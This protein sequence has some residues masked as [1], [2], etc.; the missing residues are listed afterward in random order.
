MLHNLKYAA[1]LYVNGKCPFQLELLGY[2]CFWGPKVENLKLTYFS[3]KDS[4]QKCFDMMKPRVAI[5]ISK[6]SKIFAKTSLQC[7]NF[8]YS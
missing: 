8:C 2:S 6:N 7:I 1:H 4:A 3:H 5:Y